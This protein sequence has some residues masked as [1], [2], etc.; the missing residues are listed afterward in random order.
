MCP[1]MDMFKVEVLRSGANLG[2]TEIEDSHWCK[3]FFRFCVC[4]S[5]LLCNLT[6]TVWMGFIVQKVKIE[7]LRLT[8]WEAARDSGKRWCW[9]TRK[10]R[11]GFINLVIWISG[12]L[13]LFS[14]FCV[15]CFH[16]G[17]CSSESQRCES[18]WRTEKN[19][20]CWYGLQFKYLYFIFSYVW[21]VFMV[22]NLCSSQ[23]Q[24]ILVLAL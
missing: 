12:I 21:F 23:S 7:L 20:I 14:L 3:S 22:L 11:K 18:Q 6:M 8:W 5:F 16:L 15:L 9:M 10:N 17:F 1:P 24:L 4:F 2:A 19:S 13:I